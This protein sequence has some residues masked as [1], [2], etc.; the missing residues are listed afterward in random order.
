PGE[1]VTWVC[2][3]KSNPPWERYLTHPVLFFIALVLGIMCVILGWNIAGT[4]DLPPWPVVLGGSLVVGSIFVLGFFNALFTRLVVTNFRIVILQGREACRSWG[5]DR[6]PLSLI[7]YSVR[8]GGGG[9]SDSEER[10]ID[11]DAVKTMLGGTSG[12]FVERT[13]IM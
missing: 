10:T 8:G 11:H 1:K 3:P 9:D 12:Q 13:S 5:L 4:N 2:G 7:R 6:L